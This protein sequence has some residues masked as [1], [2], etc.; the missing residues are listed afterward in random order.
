MIICEE[1]EEPTSFSEKQ[2]KPQRSQRP[3]SKP[4]LAALAAVFGS[5]TKQTTARERERERERERLIDVRGDNL[6]RSQRHV[7]TVVILL[8]GLLNLR[9]RP[10]PHQTLFTETLHACSDKI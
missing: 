2:L 9:S 8:V 3:I 4:R 1:E 5:R 10:P 6:L 7:E